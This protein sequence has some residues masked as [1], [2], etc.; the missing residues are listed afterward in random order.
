MRRS[1]TERVL[2]AAFLLLILVTLTVGSVQ[3]LLRLETLR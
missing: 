2:V 3:F 1:E